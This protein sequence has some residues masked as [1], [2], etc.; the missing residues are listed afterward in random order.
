MGPVP[1]KYQRIRSP[2]GEGALTIDFVHSFNFMHEQTTWALYDIKVEFVP[3]CRSR[4]PGTWILREGGKPLGRRVGA[5]RRL[6]LN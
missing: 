4:Q 1:R 3:F 5:Q 2:M 6:R